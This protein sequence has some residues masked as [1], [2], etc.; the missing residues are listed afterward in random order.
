M[1]VGSEVPCE[2]YRDLPGF[3]G[4]STIHNKEKAPKKPKGQQQPRMDDNALCPTGLHPCALSPMYG[5]TTAPARAASTK[6]KVSTEMG[7]RAALSCV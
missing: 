7:E 4:K 1:T 3:L 2:A 6:S 5:R